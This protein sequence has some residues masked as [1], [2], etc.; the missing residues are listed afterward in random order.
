VFSGGAI[1]FA[2]ARFA[3]G[4]VSFASARFSGGTTVWA[5]GRPSRQV[6]LGADISARKGQL[7]LFPQAGGWR[8]RGEAR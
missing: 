2:E 1:R 5:Q 3:G 7:G 8:E 6:D 4:T